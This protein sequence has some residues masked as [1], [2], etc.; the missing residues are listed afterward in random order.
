MD[1]SVYLIPIMSDSKLS[2]IIYIPVAKRVKEYVV[3][4]PG[5]SQII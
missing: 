5:Y 3:D 4:Y 2:T 1:L